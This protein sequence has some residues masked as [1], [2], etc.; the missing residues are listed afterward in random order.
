MR[1]AKRGGETLFSTQAEGVG[2]LSVT[3]AT[4]WPY[5]FGVHKRVAASYAR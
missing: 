1:V 4:V 3:V 5:R 2:R